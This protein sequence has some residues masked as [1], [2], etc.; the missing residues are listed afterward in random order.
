MEIQTHKIE[1]AKM[2]WSID[3]PAI[4]QKIK[5]L[6]LDEDKEYLVPLTTVERQEIQIGIEQFNKGERIAFDGFLWLK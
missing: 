5:T 2:I 4:L 6:L 1:L 3:N